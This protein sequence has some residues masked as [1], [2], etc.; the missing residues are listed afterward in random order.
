MES[1]IYHQQ[2]YA[3]NK[4]KIKAYTKKYYRLHKLKL[5]ALAKIYCQKNKDKIKQYIQTHK[6]ESK[7]YRRKH[8]PEI[9]KNRKRYVTRNRSR[10]NDLFRKW[11]Y[12]KYHSDPCFK[13][14]ALQRYRIWI[15]IKRSQAIKK[16][17]S[18]DLLGCTS[19]QLKKHLEVLWTEGMDWRNYGK[20]G[21]HVDHIKPLCSFDLTDK[22]Q[23]K[24][25]FHFTN[26]QPMWAED[27]LN[28]NKY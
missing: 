20:Y 22:D 4:D 19:E 6:E 15:C 21:W 17:K 14:V 1:S 5:V 28:K 10:I 26:L 11:K 27:N 2:Y 12:K 18:M 7:K 3:R 9:N 24:T 8:Q 23:Q 25:A 16:S 13:I